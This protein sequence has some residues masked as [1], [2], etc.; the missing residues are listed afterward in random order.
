MNHYTPFLR[1]RYISQT[2]IWK[3]K[4]FWQTHFLGHQ[5]RESIA[6]LFKTHSTWWQRPH[7]TGYLSLYCLCISQRFSSKCHKFNAFVSI[8]E[9]ITILLCFRFPDIAYV[10]LKMPNLH[11]LPVNISNQNG[12]IVKVLILFPEKACTS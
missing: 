2:S 12:P 4:K 6:H 9:G 7:W 10:H 1:S 5:I 3:W 11:F 8:I